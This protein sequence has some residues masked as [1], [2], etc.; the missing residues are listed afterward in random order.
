MKPLSG[1]TRLLAL[2]G[3][4]VSHSLSP[5][6]QNGWIAEA[7]LDAIYVALLV[8]DAPRFFP[9]LRASA[10][11][12]ANV[13]VPHKPAAAA[14]AD[15]LD[16]AARALGAANV[17]RWEPDGTLAG[18]NTDAPGLVAALD[19]E[20][21]GW[22]AGTRTALVL[23][24]GGAGRAMVWGLAQAGVE[25][26][27]VCN[28]TLGAAEAAAA[29][30]PA[31]QPLAWDALEAGFAGADLIV[32][33]TSLGMQGAPSPA[34]PIEA[35]P[36]HALVLDAVYAPLETP[37]L[38]AARARG[39][40]ALDGLGLLIHQGAQSFQLW[41]GRDPDIA[42]ARARLLAALGERS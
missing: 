12:G 19:G 23:G 11:A 18:F 2:F 9:A 13:T 15:T 1:R 24:A 34:W 29:L 8:S 30:S 33:A 28:R 16:A 14:A 10:W 21:P 5:A 17:L 7:G 31:A 32:N 27:L 36:A 4:P 25:R 37:L 20:A 3:D 41:F 39:L 40:H 22:R 42:G 26:I 38:R 35:A 6:L